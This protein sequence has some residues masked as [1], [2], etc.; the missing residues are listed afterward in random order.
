MVELALPPPSSSPSVSLATG[1]PLFVKGDTRPFLPSHLGSPQPLFLS[2][3]SSLAGCRTRP[4][5]LLISLTKFSHQG[6][7]L[8]LR[9]SAKLNH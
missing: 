8:K 1:G 3:F 6:K 2:F 5:S 7:S 4:S 9:I